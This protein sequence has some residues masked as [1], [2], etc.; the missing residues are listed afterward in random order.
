MN[1]VL[2]VSASSASSLTAQ[3]AAPLPELAEGNAGFGKLGKLTY[4]STSGRSL[5]AQTSAV[6]K[7][8]EV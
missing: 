7:T 8:T 1:R 6:A 2:L 3:P 5:K 4:R